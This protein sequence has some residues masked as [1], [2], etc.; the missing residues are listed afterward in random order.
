[1]ST[2]KL[3]RSINW[4]RVPSV[5]INWHALAA[6]HNAARKARNERYRLRNVAGAVRVRFG[7]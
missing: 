7:D 2:L 6:N 4:F 5:G 1:M 3:K